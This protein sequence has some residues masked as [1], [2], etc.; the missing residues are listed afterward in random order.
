[1]VPAE[2]SSWQK[3]PFVGI[4]ENGELWGRGTLD[5]KGTLCSALEAA[6]TLMAAGFVPQNDIYFAFAADEEVAGTDA[7]DIVKELHRRNITAA[8][9]VDEGGAVVEGVFPGVKSPCALIGTAEKGMLNVQFKV[10]SAGGHAS[11]PPP[12]TPVGVLAQAVVRAEGHPFPQRFAPPTLALFDTL[13]RHAPFAYKL[14]FANLWCFKGLLGRVAGAKLPELNALMRTTCAFTM[15]QASSAANVLP[16]SASV[17]ANLRLLGNTPASAIEYL[18]GVIKDDS[19]ELTNLYGMDPS[20]YSRTDSE[21]WARVTAAVS[22]TWP[23]AIVSPYL[24]VACSDSRHY[25]RIS[26]N[27]YRFSAMELSSDDRK[28]IHANDERI[29]EEKLLDAVRFYLRLI[30]K[31]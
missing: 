17:V 12:H 16:P 28:R 29:R 31:S 1:M 8:L 26:Q 11:T 18:R 9:V 2:E 6:E 5:T 13:G 27:V 19:I 4:R 20:P 14:L 25:C 22:E 24:M 10:K 21:G 15:M 23:Q 3:P 30:K 7:P